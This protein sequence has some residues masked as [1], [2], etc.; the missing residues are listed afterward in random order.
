[1]W[2]YKFIFDKKVFCK[3]R[4]CICVS[5]LPSKLLLLLPTLLQVIFDQAKRLVVIVNIM[6]SLHLFLVSLGLGSSMMNITKTS[7]ERSTMVLEGESLVMSCEAD[8][9]WFLCVWTSPLGGKQC[10]IQVDK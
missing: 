6:H 3:N 2:K 4:R 8:Q 7:P 5:Y 10:A 1:M 9:P